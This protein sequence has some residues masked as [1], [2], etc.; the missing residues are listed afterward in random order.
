MFNN[1]GSTTVYSCTSTSTSTVVVSLY[2]VL[3]HYLTRSNTGLTTFFLTTMLVLLATCLLPLEAAAA[4]RKHQDVWQAFRVS[5]RFGVDLQR[6]HGLVAIVTQAVSDEI[7]PAAHNVHLH[8]DA[9]GRRLQD[10]VS[11]Y[12]MVISYRLDCGEFGGGTTECI[13]P[14]EQ[15]QMNENDPTDA[16]AQIIDAINAAVSASGAGG[17]VASSST[18]VVFGTPE[19]HT[20]STGLP[21]G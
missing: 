6:D 21:T 16:A 5:P 10:S 9:N 18:Q 13:G 7:G 3:V 20:P 19:Q 12:T 8:V 11:G 4:P 15:A 1:R 2:S 17:D 14:E